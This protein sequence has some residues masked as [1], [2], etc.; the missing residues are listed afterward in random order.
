M[1][2]TTGRAG[3]YIGI[4]L[5][6]MT[7]GLV[8][9]L[10]ADGL[11]ACPAEGYGD[12]R[13]LAYCNAGAYGDYDHGAFWFGLEPRAVEAAESADVLFVGS[14]R[15]QFALSAES[16]AEWFDSRG[17]SHY[18]LGFSHTENVAF[19][20]PLLRDLEP[21]ARFYVINVDDFFAD[22]PTPPA[23][24]IF[25][26][27]DAPGQYTRKRLWQFV[28]EPLCSVVPFVC[29]SELAFYRRYDDGHW[30]LNGTD[31]VSP[32]GVGDANERG[33]VADRTFELARKFVE[34]LP[35]SRSCVLL[36]L[37]P[38]E[39]TPRR[40]AVEIA[41]V[42]GLPLVAPSNQNLRTFDGSH[43]DPDSAEAFSRMF[44]AEAGGHI[45]DCLGDEA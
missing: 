45:A 44:L 43:L 21:R 1:A 2:P 13:F 24:N 31:S 9:Q 36:T 25:A 29:G 22:N 3:L 32:S 6:A 37:A 40:R 28:H 38:S 4:V 20:T 17:L 8:Y 33:E 10:R 34:R 30:V 7:L 18:L 23:A 42:L 14:S 39:R 41:Q 5:L 11:F 12:N 26:A 15:M 27:K 16:T 35:V 19:T